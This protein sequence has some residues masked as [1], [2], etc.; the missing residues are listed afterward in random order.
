MNL[1]KNFLFIFTCVFTVNKAVIAGI[2]HAPPP[3]SSKDGR[4]IFVDFIKA[5]YNL[6]YD[7]SLLYAEAETTITFQTS[8][9]GFPI[10]DSLSAP[11][12]IWLDGELVS[13]KEIDV[14]GNVSKVRIVKK[15]VTPGIH[16]LKMITNIVKGTKFTRRGVHSGFFIKDLLDR[17]FLERY[18]PSNYEFDNYQ[19]TFRVKINGS[20]SEHNVFA[21]GEV[22]EVEPNLIEIKYPEF[23]TASSVY[24]HLVP[25]NRFHRLYFNYTSISGRTFPVIIYSNFRYF[26]WHLKKK[27]LR[28][29][30]ELER[31]YGPWPHPKLIVYGTKLRGGMEYVGATATSLISLGHELHHSYFA[32]GVLPA[33]GNSGWMDEGLAS[34]RDRGYQTFSTPN[35]FSFNLAKHGPYTRK[36]DKNSYEKGRSFFAYIDYQLKALGKNGLKDFLRLYFIKRKFSL[37]TT[38]DFIHDLEEYAE[39]SFREDF[40]QYVYGGRNQIVGRTPAID[41]E[42]PHHQSYSEQELD[43]IL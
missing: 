41:P 10:F 12:K 25:K 20:W 8:D 23:Y 9:T 38:E 42:N 24:F 17:N 5:Q 3:F 2:E 37:V 30:S 39:V 28:V 18:V 19:M 33:D 27:T 32:K 31:D 21:N 4:A 36:T 22:T 14:P 16:T 43:S 40:T 13:Q 1:I 15:V 35:Y 6:T 7:N 11:Q 34:W 29:L 26:N